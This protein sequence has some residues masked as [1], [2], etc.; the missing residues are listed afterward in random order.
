[1][2][3]GPA[4]MVW[5]EARAVIRALAHDA[6]PGRVDACHQEWYRSPGRHAFARAG[7]RAVSTFARS[8]S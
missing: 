4:R 2:L 8:P 3:S 6:G 1:M 7:F 5:L